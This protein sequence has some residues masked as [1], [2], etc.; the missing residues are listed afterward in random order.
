MPRA[1]DINVPHPTAGLKL[2]QESP[3]LVRVQPVAADHSPI[4]EQHRDI[5]TVPTLEDR[6]TVDVDHL[7]RWQG[8]RASQHP[9]LAQHLIAQ[10]TVVPMNDS[11]TVVGARGQ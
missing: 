11:Q 10:L 3:Q 9:Q 6:I 4:Q 1:E 7:D 5:Q 8:G 2:P